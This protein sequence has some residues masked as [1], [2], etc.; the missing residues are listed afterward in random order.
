MENIRIKTDK[1]N[2]TRPISEIG[3]LIN[4]ET[5][6]KEKIPIKRLKLDNIDIHSESILKN[7]KPL[8][9]DQHDFIK[10]NEDSD[11]E[12][13]YFEKGNNLHMHFNLS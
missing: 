6:N 8:Q 5:F 13:Y 7:N 10:E 11:D 1:S 12:I 3:L 2:L 9:K 4:D